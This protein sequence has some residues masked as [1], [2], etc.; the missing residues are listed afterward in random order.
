MKDSTVR[1]TIDIP[2]DLYRKLKAQAA[3]RRCSARELILAGIQ[4]VLLRDGSD[5]ANRVQFPLLTSEGPKVDLTN[6]QIY[7]HVEF[8]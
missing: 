8:P 6:E 7:E 1:T 2:V 5:R 4:R 3:A